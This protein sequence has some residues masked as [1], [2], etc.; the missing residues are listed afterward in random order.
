M[1]KRIIIPA[2]GLLFAA[3]TK[4]ISSY[5][6]QTKAASSAPASTLFSNAVRN[7][8]DQLA[9]SNVNVNIFRLTVQHWTTTTYTDEPNYDFTTRNIPGA[10]WTFLYRD[11][12]SD[13]NE[14]KRLV[15]LDASLTAGS[16]K[17]QVAIADIMQVYTYKILVDDFGNI[18][19][20]E[21]LDYNILFPKYDDAKTIYDD[22]LK[23]L[24]DDLGALDPNETPFPAKQDLLY[25]SVS[26]DPAR[27]RAWIKF[28]NSLKLRIA[29]TLADV[30]PAKAKSAF[31]QADAGAFSSASDNALFK[32]YAVTPNN[33]PV[34]TDLVQAKRQDFIAADAL[35]SKMNALSD[36]RIS[37]YF[38]PNDNG[39]Y[40][41][42]TAGASNPYGLYAKPSDK[43]IAMDFPSVLLDYTEVEFY[44]AE[45]AERGYSITGTAEQHYNN[46]ITS[47]IIY[48]GGSAAQAA[49][50]LANP[51][52]A[53][54][55][56]SGTYKEKI[57]TQAWIGLYNRPYEAWT[58]Y[59]RLDYP[60]LPAPARPKSGFPNRMT[61][62]G[63][64]QQLNPSNYTDAA[65]KIGGD[66]VET[67]LFWDKF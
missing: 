4:D 6:A 42:G 39:Q 62:P 1:K 7:L 25:G 26:S 57:G 3:C 11:V 63:S 40:V 20:S 35:M 13:L 43:M 65:S 51:A 44:R 32:Y 33:N 66:K 21:S 54:S 24:N 15:N 52:V 28:A 10:W 16:K 41:G 45:A 50:Y 67:K 34:W 46:A 9:S 31:E 5:N 59:R 48:W 53:Y 8:S 27:V 18:P 30:D 19:Y 47:S 17:M 37:L 2:I 36:P 60:V 61:Y 56:A 12:L 23:R 64:E 58:Q 49:A 29:I 38:R 14:S 55:T 22:L